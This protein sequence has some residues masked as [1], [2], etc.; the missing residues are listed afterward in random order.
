MTSRLPKRGRPKV[1]GK[2]RRI[3]LR[4]ATFDLWNARRETTGILGLTNSQ[5][6]EMLLRQEPKSCER[7]SRRRELF[8]STP[9]RTKSVPVAIELSLSPVQEH[10]DKSNSLVD[11]TGVSEDQ[12]LCLELNCS[13][14]GMLACV[15]SI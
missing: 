7:T 4:E 15:Q 13:S 2:T 12:N 14:S 11:I 10:G 5:F 9:L 8:Q 1:P 3:L 6:A